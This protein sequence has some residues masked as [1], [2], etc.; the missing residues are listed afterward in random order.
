MISGTER[1]ETLRTGQAA[2]IVY[3]L[4]GNDLLIGNGNG[5]EL[6]GGKGDDTYQVY[7]L[8][9]VVVEAAGKGY[10]T[11]YSQVS[12]TLGANLEALY[13]QG[14]A[15]EGA[16]NALDNAIMG[17]DLDN[18]LYGLGGKDYLSSGKG[19]DILY[20]GAGDDTLIGDAGND[21]LYGDDGNDT[22]Y[23]GVGN[24]ILYGG[25]GNDMIDGGQGDDRMWGGEGKDSFVFRN[26]VVTTKDFDEIFDFQP[27]KDLI[28]LSLIDANA[29]T[30]K[31]DAFKLI[32]NSAFHKVAGE[33][34][35]KAYGDGVLVAGDVNG[36]GAADFQIYVHNV[37]ALSSNNFYL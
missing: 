25:A 29:N 20:G 3:G 27:G 35:V 11:V 8:K 28:S 30:A 16:G 14:S 2:S 22:L 1:G 18:V 36:D 24:D 5:S 10:D 21:T 15:V 32:G 23:G 4:G 13:L 19:N 17:N 34:Q 6:H 33:L 9:D 26:E 31:D 7:S 37:A 12:Y